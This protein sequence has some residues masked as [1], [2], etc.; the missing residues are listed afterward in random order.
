MSGD[1]PGLLSSCELL[2]HFSGNKVPHILIG[3]EITA[4]IPLIHFDF[5]VCR[6]EW[7]V[8]ALSFSLF[9]FAY[10]EIRK[11]IIRWSNGGE[12]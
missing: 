10:D 2:P 12:S 7:C 9:I 8:V 3:C 6:L 4:S 1:G 11:G 5:L